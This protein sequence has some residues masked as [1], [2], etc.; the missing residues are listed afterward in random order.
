MHSNEA[1]DISNSGSEPLEHLFVLSMQ[2]GAA[3]FNYVESLNAGQQRSVVL[4]LKDQGSREQVMAALSRKMAESLV[5]EGLYKREAVAMVNTWKDSWFAED[6]VRVL[7]VL[8]RAWTDRILPLTLDPA[9]RE[10]VRVMVGRAEVLTPEVQRKLAEDLAKAS[11]GDESAR[12]EVIALFKKLGRFAE[13]ALRL[14]TKG[15]TSESM[16][17]AWS[18]YQLAALPTPDKNVASSGKL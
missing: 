16:Q 13:P 1:L 8:P 2:D 3:G 10:T 4:S 6:G 18:L 7:Y 15:E 12:N 11:S 5:H 14:A 9:P 17:K